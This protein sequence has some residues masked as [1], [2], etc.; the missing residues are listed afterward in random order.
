VG[1]QTRELE[2]ANTEI[3]QKQKSIMDSIRYARIIQSSLLPGE[4]S[5]N[6]MVTDHFILFKPRDTAGGNF[7]WVHQGD[8]HIYVAAADC[9]GHGVPGAFMSMLGMALLSKI[10]SKKPE[11]DPELLLN[12]LRDQII[13]TLHQIGAPGSSMDSMDMVISKY[14]PDRKKLQFA[15]AGNPLYL[16]RGG[17][18][19]EYKTE[20]MPVSIHGVMNPFSGREISIEPG[21]AVYMFSDG[22]ADQFGGPGGKKFK[23][24]EFKKLIVS[25]AD[26]S[27][28]QQGAEL[29]SS[30]ERWKGDLDQIEDVV[31]IGLKF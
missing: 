16:L 12:T 4:E 19:T 9:T 31:V 11:V 21:D 8:K 24:S 30:F 5:L 18:L 25:N 10:V 17:E 23:H 22:Y 6:R 7:Y 2:V 27:M 15:G 14:S 1:E 26:K 20:P 28:K 29:D 3:G 13:E